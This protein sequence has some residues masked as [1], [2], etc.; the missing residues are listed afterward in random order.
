MDYKKQFVDT[1]KKY[2]KRDGID[3]LLEQLEKTDFYIAPAS[4]RFH[5]SEPMG[6][7]KHSLEVFEYLKK[8][9][10]PDLDMT[11]EQN[12]ERIAI[13]SLFHDLCKIGYYKVEMR[14]T[15]DESGK[16]VQVPYYTI[17]NKF[18]YGHSEQSVY[19]LSKLIEITDEEA[20]AIRWHMGFS[21]PKENY[22]YVGKAFE[23]FP[24]C[25][26]LH[27]ADTLASHL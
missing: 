1:V 4:S 16:W 25:M 9:Y 2:I 26:Y 23:M 7:V 19:M 27:F 14:N 24:L 18:P 21:E 11:P 22:M 6:L 12:M 8:Y 3:E 20:M 5:D 10:N 13:V 17:D 15:K